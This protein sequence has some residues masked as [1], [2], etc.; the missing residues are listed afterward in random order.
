MKHTE[1][2]LLCLACCLLPACRT[3]Q[4]WR[5]EADER[6]T[7]HLGRAQESLLGHREE[8]TVETPADS[9]RRRLLLDQRLP[10]ATLASLGLRDIPDNDRWK[11]N[12]QLTEAPPVEFPWNTG[13]TLHL[14]LTDAVLIAAKHSREYQ[15]Q[16]DS[17]FQAALALDL[18]EHQ[19]QNT[20]SG[21]LSST[22]DS[23]Y[24]GSSRNN[25]LAN[26][27]KAGVA[28]TF[29]TG[30]ELAASLSVDLVKMLTG[31]R[32]SSWGVL[33]DASLTIPL[34]RGS[35]EFI[36][37]EPLTQAQRNLVYH[38]R[39]FEQYKRTFVVSVATSYLDVLQ[40]K[41]RIL[42]QEENYRRVVNSTRRSRR[43]AD[44]GLLP[45][46]QFD[47][48]VQDVLTARDNWIAARQHYESNLDNFKILIGLPPD[49][50]IELMT[51][52]LEKL[53]QAGERL[54]S[55]A[56]ADE[57]LRL[58]EGPADSPVELTLPSSEG[59]GPWEI[60]STLAVETALANRS[61]LR[62]TIDKIW[63]AQR[64][65]LIAEDSL[66]AE[67]TLGGVATIGE[68]RSLSQADMPD[69]SFRPSQ[70]HFQAPLTFNL[71]LERTRER[72]LYRNSLIALEKAVRQMQSEE[73]AIK[74][75]VRSQLRNLLENRASIAIQR[76]AVKLAERRVKSTGLLLQAG[77]AEMRDVLEAQSALLNAQN[78][79]ISALVSYRLNELGLQRDLG[80][81]T[82]TVDGHWTE[83]TLAEQISGTKEQEQP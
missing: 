60:D 81:L 34:L 42:N 26:R 6:A 15:N 25:G 16:K 21:M 32:S 77:R 65:V 19:F 52:E 78:A 74:K 79:F 13:E 59:A 37:G 73:D 3:S 80:L 2:L 44:A 45:E 53:Q 11:G 20:F 8:I 49:A 50:E 61:D 63:D 57:Q 14:S 46:N 12:K 10:M 18:E 64:A 31:G 48:T 29:Q 83:T 1:V 62:N 9:L 4:D 56:D 75:S 58:L 51:E 33:A 82:V 47:Q 7:H 69:G 38:V 70:G 43:M 71:P 17:L 54:G 36:V 67:L 68:G 66:R 41:Q 76:Q 22:F 5:R 39:D 24:N 27:A 40:A 55:S 30:T 28:R 72:N 23:S 35:G